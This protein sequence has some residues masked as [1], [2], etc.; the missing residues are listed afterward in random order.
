L[1]LWCFLPI[2]FSRLLFLLQFI[3]N[4]SLNVFC[5]SLPSLCYRRVA[6]R[7][8]TSD[9]T[10]IP[11]MPLGQIR[12]GLTPFLHAPQNT[13]SPSQKYNLWSFNHLPSFPQLV[14]TVLFTYS[15][16]VLID[17]PAGLRNILISW[18]WV[19]MD[20]LWPCS[21]YYQERM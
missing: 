19:L 18:G 8:A 15:V 4:V 1:E 5:L 6:V 21:R 12:L 14:K 16:S 9:P 13:I 2:S 17:E 10:K 7:P 11:G 3:F 20:V